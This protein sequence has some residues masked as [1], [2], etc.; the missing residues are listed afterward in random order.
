MLFRSYLHNRDISSFNSAGRRL[1]RQKQYLTE[2]AA[3][4]M[5]AVKEDITL[6]VTLYGTL[7]RYMVTDI[8]VDEVGY[9]ATQA[10]GY[11]LGE[12]HTLEGETV[13]GEQFEEFYPD[14]EALYRLILEVFYEEV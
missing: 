2:Y 11:R 4:A 10:A 12:I 7:S 6:P 3:A 9:L 1:Q 13:M 5:E 14:E 8:S